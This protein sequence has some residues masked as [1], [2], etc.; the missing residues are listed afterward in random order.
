M[1]TTYA[2]GV[3][4]TEDFDLKLKRIPTAGHANFALVDFR[5]L[6]EDSEV[7]TYIY[8]AGSA[9]DELL[10]T[11]RKT[12]DAK[13]DMTRCSV[14]FEALVKKTVSE[15]GEVTY[16][17]IESVIAWNYQ[18]NVL[19]DSSMAVTLISLAMSVVAQELTGAN[20]TPT[21]KVIDQFDHN[22]VV[23]LFA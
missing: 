22:V 12:Y 1:A 23:K 20:G 2:L 6:S 8:G 4:T 13:T 15:T 10:V 21:T 5:Q 11:A 19:A 17:P 9:S 18:G 7:A 3:P 14:R 16:A